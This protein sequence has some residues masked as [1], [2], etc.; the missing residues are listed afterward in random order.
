MV[1]LIIGCDMANGN[2]VSTLTV[3]KTDGK[4]ITLINSF[5]GEEANDLYQ[6]LTS[7][8]ENNHE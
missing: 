4:N 3:A 2:M 5:Y 7:K 8:K 6:K 1:P